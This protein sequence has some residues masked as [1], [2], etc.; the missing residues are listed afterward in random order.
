VDPYQRVAHMAVDN[1][2]KFGRLTARDGGNQVLLRQ[3]LEYADRPKLREELRRFPPGTPLILEASFGWGW[4]ADEA[5]DCGLEPHLSSSSKVAAWRQARGLAKNNKLDADLLSELW[6]QQPRWWEV[7][8]APQE[9]RDQRELLRLRMGLVAVQTMTKNRLH[10]TLHRHG[11]LHEF[12][13]L[14]GTQGRQFLQTLIQ[15]DEPLREPA[16]LTLREQLRLLDHLRQRLAAVTRVVRRVVQRT[17]EAQGWKTLPGVGWVLAQ[18]IAAEVGEARRFNGRR[19]CSYALLAPMAD[20]SGDEDGGTP[21]GRHVGHQGRVTLKWAFIEAAHGA[22]RKDAM[23]AGIF[24]RRTDHGKRDR[25]RGYIAVARKLAEVGLSCV[26]RQRPY[27]VAPPRPGQSPG[28]VAAQ[29]QQRQSNGGMNP[30]GQANTPPAPTQPGTQG[31]MTDNSAIIVEST[32]S[33]PSGNG[34]A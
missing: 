19:L 28:T 4:L 3:R 33:L 34:P 30:H 11:I 31:E 20:E 13:D 26:K 16:K 5:R 25:N 27:G 29:S 15:A 21:V 17:P 8:L 12:A 10:A 2:R 6:P 7:W 22:V 24:K 23:F 9:V 18:T 14:F 1:H 32:A